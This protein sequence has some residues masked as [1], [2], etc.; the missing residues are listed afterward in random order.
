MRYLITFIFH[1]KFTRKFYFPFQKKSNRRIANVNL[2]IVNYGLTCIR[3]STCWALADNAG[4]RRFDVLPGWRIV[5]EHDVSST[6]LHSDSACVV[7]SMR[8]WRNYRLHAER[9]AQRIR[10][11]RGCWHFWTDMSLRFGRYVLPRYGTHGFLFSLFFVPVE[12]QTEKEANVLIRWGDCLRIMFLQSRI[13]QGDYFNLR[14]LISR[15]AQTPLF[16]MRAKRT[17][18]R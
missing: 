16:R 1:L 18:Q 15:T 11:C 7:L 5:V 13:D 14:N 6:Y 9:N 8:E 10:N 2:Q 17:K 4:V 3:H 12:Y